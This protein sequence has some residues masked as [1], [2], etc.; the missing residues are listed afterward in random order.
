MPD[1]DGVLESGSIEPRQPF[2]TKPYGPS[3][4]INDPKYADAQKV[5]PFGHERTGQDPQFDGQ[6]NIW[7][8]DRGT[9]TR[10][11]RLDPRTGEFEQFVTLHPT[12]GIHDL[13]VD[14]DGLVYSMDNEC[15]PTDMCNL[16]IFDPKT[17]NG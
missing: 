7:V 8:T 2:D 17:E 15:S 10:I 12:R 16:N 14:R 4:G 5:N 1:K 3:E 6:G 11:V 13:N 9:P